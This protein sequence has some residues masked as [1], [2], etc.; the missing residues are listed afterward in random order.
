MTDGLRIARILVPVD[1]S[2]FSRHAT[3]HAVRIALAY[4]AELVFVHAVDQQIVAELTTHE[5][6]DGPQIRD[7]LWESGRIYLRENGR[8][9]DAHHLTHREEIAE[10]D[11]CAVI[12]DT[13]VRVGADL[14]V[15]GKIGRRGA[16]RILMGS[17]TRR[18]AEATDRP[19]LI[20]T[21]PP[22]ADE[23]LTAEQGKQ[24][25]QR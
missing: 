8:V 22:R 3:D 13:A 9:A 18:V 14:I 1:G 7:R 5:S 16:R 10:G 24:D 21:G 6:G 23:Q 11:P 25:R 15:M 4:G 20:V 12:C 2:E 19:V 17:V